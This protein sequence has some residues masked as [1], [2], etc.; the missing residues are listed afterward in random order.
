MKRLLFC[1][2]LFISTFSFGQTVS[3]TPNFRVFQPGTSRADPILYTYPGKFGGYDT[4]VNLNYLRA[5]FMGSGT[6]THPLTNGFG[7]NPFS[8]NGSINGVTVSIDTNKIAISNDMILSGMGTTVSGTTAT[9]ASGSYR[10]SGIVYTSGSSTNI[11]IPAQNATLDAYSVIYATST[12]LSIINGTP[13]ATPL[14]PDA[15]SGDLLIATIYIPSVAS[16]NSP[17]STGGSGGKINANNGITLKNGT[18][19]LGGPLI[20]P[21]TIS[22]TGSTPLTFRNASNNDGWQVG[23]TGV[24]ASYANGGSNTTSFQLSQAQALLMINQGGSTQTGIDLDYTYGLRALDNVFNRGFIYAG[25]YTTN[26][27]LQRLSVPSVNTVI[28]L[29]DSVKGTISGGTTTNSLTFSNA[30]SGDAS[31]TIFNGAIARTISYNSIGAVPTARTITINGTTFDLSAN[32]TWTVGSSV[33]P[34][35]GETPTGTINGSNATFTIAHT[36][37]SGSVSVF[38]NGLMERPTTD[39]TI[40][41]STITMIDIPQT[42][43]NLL[44][45]YQ[46]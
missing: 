24:V 33:T 29:A 32:R 9:V 20:S 8:F 30:G 46:Y 26:Q 41:G 27:R 38:L 45:N 39:W 36:P 44:I 16:G 17:T 35:S 28:A 12:G 3:L 22:L 11:T 4:L 1:L 6:T 34:V 5:H 43:S 2:L 10:I 14:I 21:T 25:N 15:P 13:A 18:I 42:G 19:Q 31:G 37:V 7:V 23:S 40:S